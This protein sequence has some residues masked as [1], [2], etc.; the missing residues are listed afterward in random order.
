MSSI[1]HDHSGQAGTT[2]ATIAARGGGKGVGD[3][4]I[5]APGTGVDARQH[6]RSLE[7]MAGSP[8]YQAFVK[9]EFPTLAEELTSPA[10]RRSFLKMMGVFA[11]LAGLTSCRWPKETI[12]PFTSQP[13]GFVPGVASQYATLFELDGAATG[14]LVTS[15]D[16]RPVKIE[17]NP[18]HPASRGAASPWAQASTLELYDP[19]RS[20][21][22]ILRE[23][24]AESRPGWNEARRLVAV[25][26]ESL[27]ATQ[28]EGLAVLAARSSSPT[29]AAQRERF[30]AVYPKASWHEYETL[31]RDNEREGARLAFGQTMRPIWRLAEASIIACFDAD[32]LMT[33]PA[34]LAQTRE[35][36]ARRR[37]ADAGSMNRLYVAESTVTVTG[38]SADHRLPAGLQRVGTLLVALAV[39]LEARGVSCGVALPGRPRL[40]ESEERFLRDLA[41]DLASH[42]GA[43]LVAVGPQQPPSVHALA[44]AINHGLGNSGRTVGY[45]PDPDGDRFSDASGLA[46]FYDGL[47]KGLTKAAVVL[48]GNPVYGAPAD[49]DLA[50]ALKLCP[51]S[52]HLGLYDD[53]TAAACRLHLPA[54]HSLESWGD[55]LAWDGTYAV[56]QPLIEPLYGGVSVIECLALLAGEAQPGHALVRSTFAARGGIGAGD[57]AWR[58]ALHDG[59]VEGSAPALMAPTPAAGGIRLPVDLVADAPSRDRLEVVFARDLTLG[60][61]R[62]SGN[63]WLQELPD[64]ITK[65]TW[66]NA[67]ILSPATAEALGV[68]HGELIKVAVGARSLVMGA[69]VLPGQP[70]FSITLPLGYGR[71][72]P[73]GHEGA[74]GFATGTLRESKTLWRATASV[75]AEKGVH[76]FATTQDHHAI[77]IVGLR[78]R[79]ERIGMLVR[80][81]TLPE[82]AANPEFA[83]HRAHQPK[84][85]SLFTEHELTGD[86]QW[87]MAIDL[88]S[89]TGCNA[90]VVA[91]QAENNIPAVGKDQVL[92][93]REMHW[94]RIDRYFAGDPE[95]PDYVHQPVACHHCEN[96]PCE[97]VCPV[98]ATVH[99]QEGLNAMVYNRCVG[100]RYCANN[101]PYKVRR[102]NYF[103]WFKDAAPITAM[104]QNP[105]VTIRGRGVMEK[106]TY[107][108]QR[109]ETAKI[110][111]KNAGKP[112]G[113]G[114]VVPACAQTCPAEAIVFGDLKD[115][116][117]RVAKLHAHPRSYAM[118]GE[119]N[120]KPRTQYLARIRNPRGADVPKPPEGAHS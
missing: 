57:A 32:P 52:L 4:R 81:G 101:C 109:V 12:L 90:C 37:S 19:D 84:L 6:W 23:E 64:P 43:G 85:F 8:E 112:L 100:T 108:V 116:E 35:F 44:H 87:A 34:A 106:C 78:E 14:I 115:P 33:H 27:K 83:R 31:S 107:C 1:I 73:A 94:L 119:L 89:C 91:C 111:A 39:D 59:T 53:E 29:L 10:T 99:T 15:Y 9:D 48:G 71:R 104:G 2:A 65:I 42:R 92:R 67:A 66:D 117:S 40:S 60:D 51:W 21:E 47:R 11:S 69:F 103:N 5:G 102:F 62:W 25:K 3:A 24:S 95:S 7:D 13:A 93:G 114:T 58:K 49:I 61:G 80:E 22:P 98:A 18:L 17:G 56:A 82:Y 46:A 88:N 45:I 20:R 118:L 110:G 76:R 77:D 63:P 41:D 54:A 50:P 86:H 72:G 26:F 16:G 55:G 75:S 38:T 105:E 74:V 97:Q 36:A 28:G 30:L 68:R 120:V 79:E 113:D 96:A 70:S